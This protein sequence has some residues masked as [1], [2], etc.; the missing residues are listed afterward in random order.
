MLCLKHFCLIGCYILLLSSCQLHS[1]HKKVSETRY[2]KT[3]KLH[4]ETNVS[5]KNHFQLTELHKNINLDVIQN[6]REQS[7]NYSS[8]CLSNSSLGS[9]VYLWTIYC[10]VP[11][12]CFIKSPSPP[13][14][15]HHNHYLWVYKTWSVVMVLSLSIILNVSILFRPLVG[16][17][18]ACLIYHCLIKLWV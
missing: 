8:L 7:L 13:H 18:T 1:L 9:L 16:S 6:P 14:H 10:F 4:I 2:W 15:H 3:L 12:P 17:S 5:A 11:T